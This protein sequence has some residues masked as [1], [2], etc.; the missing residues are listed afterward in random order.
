MVSTVGF[1]QRQDR[2]ATKWMPWRRMLRW[3]RWSTS[4]SRFRS[5]LRIIAVYRRCVNL[6]P[7]GTS[8]HTMLIS[9]SIIIIITTII[10]MIM[11]CP[12]AG[13]DSGQTIGLFNISLYGPKCKS[14]T[15]TMFSGECFTYYIPLSPGKE[16]LSINQ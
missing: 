1:H 7:H 5:W 9:I 15:S 16:K 11:V 12:N 3:H 10:I 14:P 8:N 2:H 13:W 4:I 6:P